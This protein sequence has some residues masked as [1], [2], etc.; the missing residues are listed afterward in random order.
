MAMTSASARTDSTGRLTSSSPCEHPASEPSRT[1]QVTKALGVLPPSLS[2]TVL[3]TGGTAASPSPALHTS[4][5]GFFHKVFLPPNFRVFAGAAAHQQAAVVAM[6]RFPALTCFNNIRFHVG[7]TEVRRVG[8]RR[9]Y[10]FSL[11]AGA[12]GRPATR[13]L[14]WKGTSSTV[15]LAD[16]ATAQFPRPTSDA[17]YTHCNGNLK[18][19]EA[20]EGRGGRVLAL[21]ANRTDWLRLGHFV[22]FEEFDE[23]A[24]LEEVLITGLS[25]VLVERVEGRGWLGGF[26]KSKKGKEA[27]A[28]SPG[29]A[30]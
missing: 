7:G 17:D 9:E 20:G 21:Y 24:G 3:P 1:F 26:G 5:V 30:D 15:H 16:G 14:V 25:I 13:Q 2:L 29:E 10:R 6:V 23:G 12:A 18:L 28:S 27:A 22:L 4:P 19:C 8:M 11:P